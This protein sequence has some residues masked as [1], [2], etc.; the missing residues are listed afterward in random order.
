MVEFDYYCDRV[1]VCVF[2][3]LN[4]PE[5]SNRFLV[6]KEKMV[7]ENPIQLYLEWELIPFWIF[8]F[9]FQELGQ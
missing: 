4:V 8:H 5:K 7:T 1:H 9:V 6:S 3:V 2:Y